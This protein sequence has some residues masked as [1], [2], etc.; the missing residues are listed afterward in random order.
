MA[1]QPAPTVLQTCAASEKRNWSACLLFSQVHESY[2]AVFADAVEHMCV[3]Q[4]FFQSGPHFRRA[5]LLEFVPDLEPHQAQM[6][7]SGAV[8]GNDDIR[9]QTA[10]SAA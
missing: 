6:V 10:L 5:H 8:L 3:V 1:A 4:V 2:E 9:M 7:S